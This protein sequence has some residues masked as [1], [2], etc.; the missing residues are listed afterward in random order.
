MQSKVFVLGLAMASAL[1]PVCIAAGQITVDGNTVYHEGNDGTGSGLDADLLDGQDATAFAASAHFHAGSPYAAVT[2]VAQSGGDYADPEV[3]MGDLASWCGTPTELNPC[4]LKILPGVYDLTG[5][6][7][8]EPFV[9]VE[10]SGI[11]VTRLRGAPAGPLV[12]GADDSELRHLTVEHTGGTGGPRAFRAFDSSPRLTHVRILVDANGA[13]PS[14]TQGIDVS[15]S[16]SPTI[17][18]VQVTA[19]GGQGL[20]TGGTGTPVYR[21]LEIVSQTSATDLQGVS[22]QSGSPIFRHLRVEVT[23]AAGI[24][25]SQRLSRDTRHPRGKHPRAGRHDHHG[26]RQPKLFTGA[27]RLGGRGLWG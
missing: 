7:A 5:S 1:I 21:D 4:L 3:A 26:D 19:I 6:L 9:D 22:I 23:G 25:H 27:P 24:R 16:A 8:M 15:G 14:G 10:G 2:V 12:D 17:S 13:A 20:R 18:H 11:F